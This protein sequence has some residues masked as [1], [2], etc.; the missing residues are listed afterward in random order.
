MWS[1]RNPGVYS[2]PDNWISHK[3]NNRRLC[4]N[5]KI[6]RKS[7]HCLIIWLMLKIRTLLLQTLEKNIVQYFHKLKGDIWICLKICVDG[8]AM[9]FFFIRFESYESYKSLVSKCWC[10]YPRMWMCRCHGKMFVFWN[11]EV[12]LMIFTV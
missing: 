6:T 4:G 9:I 12:N 3:N 5:L 2:A 11:F 10:S 1:V 7:H 8:D